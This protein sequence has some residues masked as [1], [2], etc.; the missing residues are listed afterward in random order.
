[1][2]YLASDV[3]YED[4]VS[5]VMEN[6]RLETNNAV[7]DAIHNASQKDLGRMIV[8]ELGSNPE[9]KVITIDDYFTELIDKYNNIV[10]SVKEGVY[11]LYQKVEGNDGE[12]GKY[13]KRVIKN[14]EMEASEL[15]TKYKN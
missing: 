4:Y 1:M 15:D 13:V 5:I 2:G 8:D 7:N 14:L 12:M 11:D 3:E 6:A 9:N 10:G